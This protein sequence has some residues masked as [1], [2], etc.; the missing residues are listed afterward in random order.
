MFD[1]IVGGG[2]FRLYELVC[3]FY[4][5]DFGSEGGCVGL[6]NKEYLELISVVLA[7]RIVVYE[8]FEV[9]L[10]GELFDNILCLAF[11]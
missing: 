6:D 4:G 8:E 11:S 9:L 2:K 10:E 1:G 5:I 7:H 3:F